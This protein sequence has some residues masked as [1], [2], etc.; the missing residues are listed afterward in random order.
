VSGRAAY[1]GWALPGAERARLLALFPPAYPDLVADHVTLAHGV[2]RGH[3]LPAARRAR[4]VG[5]VDDGAGLQA[6]VVEIDGA[7]RRPDGST[8]HLT[9]SLDRARG[10][11]SVQSN[12]AIRNL[13]WRPVPPVEIEIVP[14]RFGP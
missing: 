4:V 12:D 14:R 3:P 6:L 8:Y 2:G 7:T 13:G 11:R 1:V 10:R 5:A 9:W